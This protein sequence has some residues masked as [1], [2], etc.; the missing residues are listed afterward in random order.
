MECAETLGPPSAKR[1]KTTTAPSQQQL[2]ATEQILRVAQHVLDGLP[3]ATTTTQAPTLYTVHGLIGQGAYGL[4]FS[5]TATATTTTTTTPN[6][7]KCAIKWVD[8]VRRS[9]LI[10]EAA[11]MRRVRGRDKFVQLQAVLPVNQH[12]MF[13]VM[14]LCEEGDLHMHMGRQV[15]GRLAPAQVEAFALDMLWGLMFLHEVCHLMHRDLK[16]ANLLLAEGGRRLKISDLGTA[17]CCRH[18]HTSRAAYIYCTHAFCA[19]EVLLGSRRYGAKVDLWSAGVVI[20]QMVHGGGAAFG[21]C[22]WNSQVCVCFRCLWWWYDMI[23]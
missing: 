11:A 22:L 21:Q 17:C 18:K 3:T 13:F 6:T 16:P 1:A 14:E 15:G 5:G 23:L 12:S 2:A 4:V 7:T 10:R 8:G 19:P 20:S 9:T